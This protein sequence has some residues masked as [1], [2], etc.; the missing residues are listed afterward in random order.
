MQ[1]SETQAEAIEE[2]LEVAECARRQREIAQIA[3]ARILGISDEN[4][5]LADAFAGG[6]TMEKMLAMTNTTV[7]TETE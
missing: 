1:I 2:L 4:E 5:W 6:S 7:K 3:A